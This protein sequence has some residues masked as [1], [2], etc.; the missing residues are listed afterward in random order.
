MMIELLE[1]RGMPVDFKVF[2]TDVHDR[3]LEGAAEGVYGID[4]LK[5]ITKHQRE[6]FFDALGNDKYKVK[7][8]LRNHLIFAKHNVVND[9]PF[10]GMDLVTCRNL[11]IYLQ[12]DAQ[13]SAIK[14][15]RFAL[16]PEG[17]L[18]LGPSE[19][20]GRIADGFEVID[21]DWRLF[22]K[23]ERILLSSDTR[24][25]MVKSSRNKSGNDTFEL[26][27]AHS[28]IKAS[29]GNAAEVLNAIFPPA[30]L[31]DDR[32]CV[33]DFFRGDGSIFGRGATQSRRS[34]NGT[35]IGYRSGRRLHDYRSGRR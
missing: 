27:K 31:I 28:K 22:Q 1:R 3:T 9:P 23:N 16:K 5:V 7:A 10:T 21:K 29:Q 11:L 30:L 20:L 34:S 19:T 33:E 24:T 2:A 13:L 8:L 32:H 12:D 25:R 17:F 15:F 35:V 4:V 26:V 18:M 14:G 6:R